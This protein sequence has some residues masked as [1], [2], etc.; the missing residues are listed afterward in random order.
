ME[1][2]FQNKNKQQQID[3]QDVL[4]NAAAKQRLWLVFG[5]FLLG[6]VALLLLIIYRNKRKAAAVLA[7]YTRKW[8]DMTLCFKVSLSTRA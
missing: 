8:G 7:A 2:I 5:L 4:L 3:A 1:V 6:L